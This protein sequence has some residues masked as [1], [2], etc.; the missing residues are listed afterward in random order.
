MCCWGCRAVGYFVASKVVFYHLA[1]LPKQKMQ[2][3]VIDFQLVANHVGSLL[4]FPDLFHHFY[5]PISSLCLLNLASAFSPTQ[6]WSMRALMQG[7]H[8]LPPVR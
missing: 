4:R 2:V 6:P 8:G 1:D 7:L 3:T 5:F